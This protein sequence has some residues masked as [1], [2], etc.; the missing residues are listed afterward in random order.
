[1]MNAVAVFRATALIS[2]VFLPAA[3][4]LCRARVMANLP[5]TN[6]HDLANK[7]GFRDAQS[8][9]SAVPAK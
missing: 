9:E 4:T 1:M 3:D 7:R 2:R 6:E 5:D 8:D